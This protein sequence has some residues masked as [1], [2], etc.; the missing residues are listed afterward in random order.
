MLV[1]T[2]IISGGVKLDT[3][4]L[5]GIQMQS[6]QFGWAG[7][8]YSNDNRQAIV[9][10]KNS[11]QNWMVVN[12]LNT[13]ILSIYPIDIN[14]AW[15]YGLTKK[16]NNELVPTLFYTNN[17]GNTWDELS[18]PVTEDWEKTVEVGISL[19]ANSINSVWVVLTRKITP[20]IFEH[21]LYTT[22]NKGQTWTTSKKI[23]IP[24]PITGV[25]FINTAMGFISTQKNYKNP[26]VYKTSNG[27]TT[28]NPL[29]NTQ[30]PPFVNQG[31]TTSYKPIHKGNI[32]IIPTK[33]VSNLNSYYLN[34]SYDQGN[35]WFISNK[36]LNTEKA[37]ISFFNVNYGWV[38]DSKNG[39][40]YNIKNQS[41]DWTNISS[42]SILTDVFCLRFFNPSNGWAC[43]HTQIFKTTNGGLSWASVPYVIDG[44]V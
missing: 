42:S 1:L 2:Y 6:N 20:D 12:P 19:H 3:I 29:S 5:T 4:K 27:G 25:T 36:I 37:A 22:Q 10:T 16:A 43:N 30:Y 41:Q 44:V 15:V 13:I 17:K 9:Y 38:I 7:I 14:S 28:W 40:T 32:I 11:G 33:I 31:L 23:N 39:L 8:Q 24:G 34:I 21:N 18:I 26:T 35:T